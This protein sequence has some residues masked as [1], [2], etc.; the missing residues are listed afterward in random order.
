MRKRV[1]LERDPDILYLNT[2]VV[3]RV[4]RSNKCPVMNIHH[5]CLVRIVD[6][7]VI[8]AS[9][10]WV[11]LDDCKAVIEREDVLFKLDTIEGTGGVMPMVFNTHSKEW[12][13]VPLV[14]T[15]YMEL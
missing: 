10:V 3:P 5:F 13:S 15:D 7:C 12:V 9:D 8:E 6:G 4:V 2:A 1:V 14:D 11:R